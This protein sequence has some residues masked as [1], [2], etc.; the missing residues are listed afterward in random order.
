MCHIFGC[1]FILPLLL[2]FT[3]S[4]VAMHDHSVASGVSVA[5]GSGVSVGVGVFC[6]SVNVYVAMSDLSVM[7]L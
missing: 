2:P 7:P 5:V 6:W 3:V 4:S 1:I